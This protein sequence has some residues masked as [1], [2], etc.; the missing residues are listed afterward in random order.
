VLSA[1]EQPLA[2]LDTL[3]TEALATRPELAAQ[4]AELRSREATVA[5]RRLDLRPDF[6]AMASYDSMWSEEEH[7]WMVGVGLNLPVFRG[8]LRAGVAEAEAERD[9]VASRRDGLVDRITAEVATA[10]ARVEESGH[11]LEL[12]RSRLLPA[13]RDQ[14][15][16]ALVGFES[17]RNSFLALIEAERNQRSV[18]LAH[19]Q[20]LADAHR[21]RAELD[22]AVGRIGAIATTPGA[23]AP[24]SEPQV[25]EEGDSR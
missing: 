3:L 13:S 10:R 16:A 25:Y 12:Y 15:T 22:R 5:L 24:R 21:A 9:I 14:V 18:Q 1:P 7:R 19:H 23:T 8:R 20:A 2:E 17:G 6:E 4:D 11:V